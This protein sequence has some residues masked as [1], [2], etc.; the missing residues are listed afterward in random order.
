MQTHARSLLAKQGGTI[1]AQCLNGWWD[2]LPLIGESAGDAPPAEGWCR[3]AILVPSFWTK[4][5]DGVRRPGEIY[6]AARPEGEFAADDEFLFDAFGY[7]VEWSK[8]RSG[9]LRRS[10][11]LAEVRPDRRYFVCLDAVCPR[12]TVFVNGRRFPDHDHPTLPVSVDVTEA[13]R[14]GDNELAVLVRDYERDERGRQKVP[15]GNW[16]PCGHSG[17]WQDVHLVE[18]GDAYA[19][20]VAIVTST[21]KRT[22][23]A[24]LRVAN[25]RAEARELRVRLEV[26]RWQKGADADRL[27]AELHL[28]DG[29]VRLPAGGHACVDVEQAWPEAAWWSPESPVLHQLRWS[30]FEN[31]RL[32]ERGYERFGF[33]EVWI[34]GPHIMLNDH[35]VHMFS[36]W[37]H[38]ATPYYYTEGWIRQWFGMIRDAN[39]NHSRLHTHP[40]PTLI[41]DLADEMGILI[42]GEA[43]LH[44]SG[45]AQAADCPEY[46]EAARDHVR[47]FVQRDRNRPCVIMWSVENEMRWNRDRTDLAQRE[48]PR[49]RELFHQLDST[50]TAYHEGDTSLWNERELEIVSRH[51]GKECA[52]LGWWDRKQPLHSGEMSVYHYMGPNNTLHLAG[53]AAFASYAAVDAAA[54]TDTAHIVEAGRTLGVCNFGPWN[55]SCLENLRLENETVELDYPDYSAPGVKPLRVPAHSSE[56]SFWKEGPGYVPNHSFAIQKHAFRPLALID[57]S[58]RTGYFAG[59]RCRRTLHLVNDTARD[60]DGLLECRLRAGLR[61]VWERDVPVSVERGR[62]EQVDLA[63][64]LPETGGGAVS[65]EAR[66]VSRQGPFDEWSRPWRLD[67]PADAGFGRGF[68]EPF[69]LFGPG[70]LRRLGERLGLDTARVPDLAAKTLKPFRLLVIEKDA[71]EP[72][73]AMNRQ[74]QAFAARG[75]R[76]VLLEQS[77]SVF[78]SLT[79]DELPVNTAFVRAPHHPLLE[80]MEDAD[81]AYWGDDPY[82][83]PGGNAAVARQLYAKDDGCQALPLLDSG[84]GGFGHGDLDRTPLFELPEGNGLVLACQLRL[85]E[86]ADSIP[87]AERILRRLLLRADAYRPP[88]YPKLVLPAGKSPAELVAEAKKGATVLVE[89]ASPEEL[90]RWRNTLDIDLRPVPPDDIYQAVRSKADPLLDGISNQDTCGVTTWTYSPANRRNTTV[91]TTF[92]EPVP[93]L[94]SLL[95][96]PTESCLKE[97]FVKLGKTEPLRAHTLSRFLF[98]EQPRRAVVL[99]RARVGKGQILFQQFAPAEPVHPGLARFRNRLLTNL[100]VS[101][102][103]SLLDGESVPQGGKSQGF[104][105]AVHLA[106]APANPAVWEEF[107]ACT[108]YANERMPNR[109]ILKAAAW[110]RQEIPDGRFPATGEGPVCLYHIIQSGVARKNLEQDIGVPNPE[111][112]SFLDL[113]GDGSVELVVN[114]KRYD[115]VTLADGTATIG[116]IEFEAGFNHVLLRWTPATADAILAMRWRNIMRRP[117]TSFAFL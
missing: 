40:H 115:R 106:P 67:T 100:G 109:P 20:D 27:P 49:L 38:K 30:I 102:S 65:W 62:V 73:T 98:A 113:A 68:A 74:I 111:A 4:P 48:L 114:G 19:E 59:Q 41:L 103:G 22:I 60:L 23:A 101:P 61:T 35:P 50:R 42:T 112:L 17:I 24:S 34:E 76:V 14:A 2:F 52:G 105:T 55:L 31:D 25:A 87:A 89:N 75:G 21:R 88:K 12:G 92:L 82:A 77:V 66:F 83:L 117:E 39:M 10:F 46:W 104:P 58:L 36:D 69:A 71:I 47:R 44:G 97:H 9:W 56:F 26:V 86:C 8:T 80:G 93:E 45:G 3:K 81:F 57:L 94:E 84:E 32:V 43:G 51:Y 116:D 53:D 11:A 64:D 28:G 54:A 5:K 1:A 15:T 63:F 16:I 79:L 110:Q 91:G 33:R 107:V 78:P 108:I 29:T 85:T 13:L 70:S 7:P 95:D 37:G 99:G 90:A 96:T 18:R 6:F 72:G